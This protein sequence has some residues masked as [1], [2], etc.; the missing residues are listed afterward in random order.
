MVPVQSKISAIIQE[1]P[2]VFRVEIK[3]DHRDSPM[4]V[5][6]PGQFNFLG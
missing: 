3:V 4:L 6:N 5:D 2:G 1:S